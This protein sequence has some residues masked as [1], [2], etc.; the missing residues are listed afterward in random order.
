[1]CD[2]GQVQASSVSKR[3]VPHNSVVHT[4]CQF[5]QS[6]RRKRCR[7][8]ECVM[9]HRLSSSIRS[10]TNHRTRT[11]IRIR[12]RSE[13]WLGRPH[14]YIRNLQSSRGRRCGT[15]IT[16]WSIRSRD[17]LDQFKEEEQEWTTHEWTKHERTKHERTKHERTKHEWK[18]HKKQLKKI[19][20]SKAQ[21]GPRC[22]FAL[23]ILI[24]NTKG[25]GGSERHQCRS[26]A[27]YIEVSN[28]LYV[29]CAELTTGSAL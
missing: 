18:E 17:A 7:Q 6:R 16:S 10:T 11:R 24:R 20:H 28:G 8:S 12:T 21:A 15:G 14:G 9:Q 23:S 13:C 22:L 29:F 25:A 5:L 2:R 3:Q 19:T 1:M 26:C 4:N 27:S